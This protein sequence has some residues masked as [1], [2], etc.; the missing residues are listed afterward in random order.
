MLC[1]H[2]FKITLIIPL[3]CIYLYVQQLSNLLNK[4]YI[5]LQDV[6]RCFKDKYKHDCYFKV[7]KPQIWICSIECYEEGD[8][9]NNPSIKYTIW[10]LFNKWFIFM[11]FTNFLLLIA[12]TLKIISEYQVSYILTYA[13]S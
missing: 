11:L 10:E 5:L 7:K 8:E 12:V 9:K 13:S 3:V 2:I 4:L 1:F 6:F